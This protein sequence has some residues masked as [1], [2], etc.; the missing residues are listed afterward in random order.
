M[1][2]QRNPIVPAR[3][4]NILHRENPGPARVP[5]AQARLASIGAPPVYR[6][7]SAPLANPVAPASHS[8]G[9]G[10]P[11]V[12]RPQSTS[13][14]AQLKPG[15]SA[16]NPVQLQIRAARSSSQRPESAAPP[17]YTGRTA[18]P[19]SGKPNWPGHTTSHKP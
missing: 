6:P 2:K 11:P 3:G 13:F 18:L 9:V 8:K 7:K 12:Y 16:K 4:G 5:Q 1:D 14:T 10:A 19:Q 15:P 17:V